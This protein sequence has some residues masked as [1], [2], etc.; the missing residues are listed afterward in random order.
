MP[1][2]IFIT[3]FIVAIYLALTLVVGVLGYRVSRK[4]PADYFLADRK[5]GSIVL[6]FTLIATNFSAFFF[7]GFAGAGYRI[8]YSYYG[9]MSFGT[10]LVALAFYFIGHKVWL[11]GKQNDY[12]TPAE[13]IGDRFKSPALKVLFLSVMVIF[14]VPYLAIQPIGAGYLLAGLTNE[15]I[16]YFW[17]AALLTLFMVVYVF[18]GGMRSVAWTDVFQGALMFVM[19]ILAVGVIAETFGGLA[20]AN[21]KVYAL[22]PDLFSRPGL[23]HYFTPQKWFSFMLLWLFCV[24]M[25]PQMFMRFFTAKTA[26][27][28]KVSAVL[29]PIVTAILFICPVIFG[30]LGHLAFPELA[31]TA[32]DQILPMMLAKFAPAW[33]AALIMVGALAAFMSTMD[34]QLLA[35]SSMLTRDIYLA[36]INRKA[37]F[38]QQVII[39]KLLVVVLATLGLMIAYKPPATIFKI[40]TETFTG[41]AVLFP[42]TLAALYW[43]RASAFGCIA[44]IIVGELLVIGFHLE[45]IPAT[46]TL[47]F[48]PVIPIVLIC[49]MIIVLTTVITNRETSAASRAHT[50]I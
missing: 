43:K 44:S 32:S 27:S 24:P 4:T 13:L 9:I 42:T 46:F 21:A 37:T 48:L 7:L 25:F 41:L 20:Q 12:I 29:Y 14:T 17:G 38:N 15:A 11:I 22:K 35:L 33:L 47:G 49:S 23:N 10:A 45:L 16:P 6:F 8:G 34:S 1:S 3:L 31:G 5:F 40:A 30:V 28:L 50:P 18:L 26:D 39:G 19:T 36:F 2:S